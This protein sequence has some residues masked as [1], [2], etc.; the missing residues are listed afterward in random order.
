MTLPGG[1]NVPFDRV[2]QPVD[3]RAQRFLWERTPENSWSDESL[4][5]RV[6]GFLNSFIETNKWAVEWSVTEKF[7]RLNRGDLT[8]WKRRTGTSLIESEKG[9][10]R[11]RGA[12]PTL[13]LR[14]HRN[15][16]KVF[17]IGLPFPNGAEVNMV[18]VTQLLALA[19]QHFAQRNRDE[20]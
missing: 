7:A 19:G 20:R 3:L 8:E 12:H 11:K 5:A 17:E 9:F 13:V 16:G 1:T 4:R 15:D 18:T 6:L 10:L 2:V 14:V